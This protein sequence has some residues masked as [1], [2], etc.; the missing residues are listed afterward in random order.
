MGSTHPP[1]AGW[2]TSV[3]LELTH[4]WGFGVETPEVVNQATGGQRCGRT[5]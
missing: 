4:C 5:V 1:W 2:P 3:T